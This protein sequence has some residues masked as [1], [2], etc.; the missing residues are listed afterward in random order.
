MVEGADPEDV[1]AFLRV[2]DRVSENLGRG[3]GAQDD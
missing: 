2:L 1:D 3:D